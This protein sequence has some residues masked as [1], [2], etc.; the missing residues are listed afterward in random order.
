MILS[1]GF[2]QLPYDWFIWKLIVP[3]CL[4]TNT[5]L[6]YVLFAHCHCYR[7]LLI[8]FGV[9]KIYPAIEKK[10]AG[11]AVNLIHDTF[12]STCVLLRTCNFLGYKVP[13][14]VD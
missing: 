10:E 14:S 4:K 2:I 13:M 6:L 12:G 8:Y 9:V 1:T 11:I 3:V 7:R 5:H